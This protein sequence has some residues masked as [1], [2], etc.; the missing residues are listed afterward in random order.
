MLVGPLQV[1]GG[2]KPFIGKCTDR[3]LYQKLEHISEGGVGIRG[4]SPWEKPKRFLSAKRTRGRGF[5]PG[6]VPSLWSCGANRHVSLPGEQRM[7][8]AMQVSMKNLRTRQG[9]D[10]Q[11]ERVPPASRCDL[12]GASTMKPGPISASRNARQHRF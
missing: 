7:I 8:Y 4:L 12:N 2:A 10:P 6:S 1:R 3:S 11:P 5:S 9:C